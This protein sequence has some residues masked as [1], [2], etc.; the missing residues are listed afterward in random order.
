MKKSLIV[1]G[2]AAGLVGLAQAENTTTLYGAIGASTSMK[3]GLTHEEGSYSQKT[4]KDIIG[5]KDDKKDNKNLIKD[6]KDT[7]DENIWDLNTSPAKFGIKGTED[8]SNGLQA[9]YKMEFGFDPDEGVNSTRYAYIGLKG[10]FGTLTLGKSNALYGDLTTYNDIFENGFFDENAHYGN[11]TKKTRV[12][13]QIRY[14]SPDMSGMHFGIAGILDGS[15]NVVETSDSKSFVGFQTGLWYEQ[16]GLYA[17]VA[18][19]NLDGDYQ[20]CLDHGKDKKECSGFT[21]GSTEVIGANVGYEND[22]FRIGLG[23]EHAASLGEKYNLAGAY[24]MGPNTFRAGFAVSDSDDFNRVIS[25]Q[26]TVGKG[27]TAYTYAL[28]YQYNFSKRTF[29]YIDGTY[30][31]Y[32]DNKVADDGYLINV[33]LRHDF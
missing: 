14:D 29:T 24:Y 17:S 4:V 18:Y 27:E 26:G 32:S 10:D 7:W 25:N 3:D 21:K 19:S 30:I 23:A 16:N 22:Q 31:D 11:L 8:L 20:N 15:H 33:G 6:V 13:K 2:I 12:A 28:G 9:F 1:L 5:D